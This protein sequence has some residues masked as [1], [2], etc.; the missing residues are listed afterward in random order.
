MPLAYSEKIEA[1][2]GE[3]GER[4][5][6]PVHFLI[7]YSSS[8]QNTHQNNSDTAARIAPLKL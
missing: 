4:F 7:Q 5:E 2:E 1:G 6:R 3:G 8:P